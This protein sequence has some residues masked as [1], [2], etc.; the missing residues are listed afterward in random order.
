MHLPHYWNCNTNESTWFRGYN[1]KY[2]ID[3]GA[4]YEAMTPAY[5]KLMS[6]QFCLRHRNMFKR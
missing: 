3:K 2:F 6:L 1:D 4:L 5:S